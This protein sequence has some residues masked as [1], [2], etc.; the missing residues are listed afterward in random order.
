VENILVTQEEQ[1]HRSLN[2]SGASMYST[3]KPSGNFQKHT[4]EI[5]EQLNH[6]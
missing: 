4:K 5:K 2:N 1:K 3:N 6:F